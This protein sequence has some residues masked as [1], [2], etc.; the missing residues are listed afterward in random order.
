VK[1]G[2]L[3]AALLACAAI[4]SLW[5]GMRAIRSYEADRVQ[6]AVNI[7][8]QLEGARNQAALKRDESGALVYVLHRLDGSTE[9]L[10]PDAFADRLHR[11]QQSRTLL[12]F[13]FNI[14]NPM[15]LVWVSIGL[16]GQLIFTGRMLV[17]WLVSER[18][19]RSVVPPA[20]WWLSVIGSLM[21]LAYFGWRMD[22]VGMIG[23]GAG[24]GIYLR[25]LH[26]I[27]AAKQASGLPTIEQ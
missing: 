21:L 2:W 27:Y 10:T 7:K 1:T 20:F 26:L 4:L 9:T 6:G 11:Q 23:Q 18:S 19:R 17:Q 8:V 13:I 14:S 16:L 25:N 3:A 22:I 12:W 5:L 15:G 24:L